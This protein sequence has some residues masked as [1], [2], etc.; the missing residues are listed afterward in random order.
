MFE[1]ENQSSHRIISKTEPMASLALQVLVEFDK[2]IFSWIFFFSTLV[3]G[4]YKV[5]M[6]G[7]P[8]FNLEV[9]VVILCI[10]QTLN[11]IRLF[12]AIKQ[13]KTEKAT[14]LAITSFVICSLVV[15]IGLGFF[16][17]MQTHTLLLELL[18]TGL[19][20]FLGIIEFIMMLFAFISF[21]NME[22]S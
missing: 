17:V 18:I 19:A 12:I 5:Y 10:L 16:L 3:L 6:Y 15:L 14:G 2:Q 20:L 8:H 4:F 11:Q 21:S 13:N 1:S 9:E 7:L 22:N